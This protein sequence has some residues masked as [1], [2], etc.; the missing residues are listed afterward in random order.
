MAFLFPFHNRAASVEF[1]EPDFDYPQTVEKNA[2]ALLKKADKQTA[3]QAGVTR[4]RAL[5]ELCAAQKAIDFT[6]CFAQPALVAGKIAKTNNTPADRAMLLL[7]QAKIYSNI[8]LN[9]RWSYDRV[10]APAEP[11]PADVSEWSGLQFRNKIKALLDSAMQIEASD[12]LSHYKDVLEYSKHATTYLPTSRDFIFNQACQIFSDSFN[13]GENYATDVIE[14]ALTTAKPK[15]PEFFYWKVL[16]LGE[17]DFDSVEQERAEWLEFYEKYKNV[18]AAR[19]VLVNLLERYQYQKSTPPSAEQLQLISLAE[20][21]LKA[22]PQWYNNAALRNSLN[23]LTTPTVNLTA[24]NVVMSGRAFKV[25]L[26]YAFAK[27][28]T[29]WLYS[30]PPTMKTIGRITKFVA[31]HRAVEQRTVAV[32]PQGNATVEF[33]APKSGRYMLVANLNNVKKEDG[34]GCILLTAS[35]FLPMVIN[36][37]ENCTVITADYLTGAP[38]PGVELKCHYSW[39]KTPDLRLGTTD[40]QGMCTLE[41]PEKAGIIQFT[42][43]GQTTSF[44]SFAYLHTRYKRHYNKLESGL[45]LT[46]RA[47]YHP[48]DSLDWAVVLA[49]RSGADSKICSGVKL[50][51]YL[52]DANGQKRDTIIVTTDEYGRANG[53]FKLPKGILTGD[54][55]LY[56]QDIVGDR[57]FSNHVMV[58]DFRPP[59]FRVEVTTVSRDVPAKGGVQVCGN[60]RT[61]AGMPVA[62]ADVKVALSGVT[63]WRWFSAPQLVGNIDVKTDSEGNFTIDFTPEMLGRKLNDGR[64]YTNF[65]AEINVVAPDASTA[66]ASTVFNVGKPYS[67]GVELPERADTSAPLPLTFKAMSADGKEAPIEIEWALAPASADGK[68]RADAIVLSGKTS[69]GKPEKLDLGTLAAGGYA[70]RLVPVDT[71]LA[72]TLCL[73]QA[74]VLYNV[75]KNQVP[76]LENMPVFL[77]QTSVKLDEDG[78]GCVQV[79]VLEPTNVYVA[80]LYGDTI[81]SVEPRTLP[82]GYTAL[83]VQVAFDPAIEGKARLAVLNVLNGRSYTTEAELKKTEK[84]APELKV[85][86]FRDKITSGNTESWRIRMLAPDGKAMP[87]IPAIA[88]MYNRALDELLPMNWQSRFNLVYPQGYVSI[89]AFSTFRHSTSIDLPAPYAKVPN[90]VWPSWLFINQYY[91]RYMTRNL[92]ARLASATNQVTDFLVVED[93]EEERAAPSMD[94][95]MLKESAVYDSAGSA[96]DSDAGASEAPKEQN[97]DFRE[98]EAL[99]AFWLP[100]LVSDAEGNIDIVFTVPNALGTWSFRAL[101]W[102]AAAQTSELS[103]EAVASKPVMVQ[104][105]LPRFLRQGDVATVLATV[106]NNSGAAADIATT[107][108]LFDVEAGAVYATRTFENRIEA[109]ASA[110]VPFDIEVPTDKSAVGYR[111]RANLGKYSDGEQALIP[112]LSSSATVIESTEFYLNPDESKPFE[113]SIPAAKD[114]SLTL[115]YCQNPIWTVVRAMRGLGSQDGSSVPVLV[116]KLFSALTAKAIVGGNPDIAKTISEWK[117]NPEED[118][119]TSMLSRN[120]DLKKLMLDQTPWVQTAANESARMAALADVLDPQKAREAIAEYCAKMRELQTADGGFRWTSWSRE[121]GE[122]VTRDVLVTLGIANSLGFLPADDADLNQ[123]LDKAWAFV[124]AEAVKPKKI[125][126]DFTL[127]YI[128]SLYPRFKATPAAARL[129]RSTVKEIEKDW[130]GQNLTAKAYAVLVLKAN[131]REAVAADILASIREFAVEKEGIGMTFPSINDIRSYATIIQAYKAMNAPAAEIDALRQWVIVQAQASDNIFA[132]NPD[133]VIAAVLLTGSDWTSVPVNNNVTLNGSPLEISKIESASGYFTRSLPASGKKMDISVQPNGITPSYGSVISIARRP[134]STVKA[135][136]GRDLSIEKRVLVNRN[137]KWIETKD[138][139]L[140][141][142]LQVQLIIKAKR[143]LDYVVID[144]E[145]PATFEPVEQL[146]GYVYADGLAFYRENLDASTRL[147]IGHMPAGTYHLSYEMTANLGGRFISGV[148]TLQSQYAP[149]LTAHSGAFTV[150]VK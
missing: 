88:T 5:L 21:S 119:L 40:A 130:K 116:S 30:I 32:S 82:A 44:D 61:F 102:T 25:E 56:A 141:E 49:S 150:N 66:S 78:K 13:N 138:Y 28:I 10:D 26:S 41:H 42:K 90:I 77:P 108:E 107:V 17:R 109:D 73:P 89:S 62:G 93:C 52:E 54:Y 58:S 72:D 91:G 76:A 71:A 105:N 140:G 39:D 33:T 85:E 110:L 121:P 11:L 118:A 22:F 23:A 1:K 120:E 45:V 63:F 148:A 2:Q 111:V 92:R 70:M 131:G 145:R 69:C 3:P 100:S 67:L 19:Y 114:A 48:G 80:L 136:P 37:D 132:Y 95:A 81:L 29:V 79:G 134:M 6:N 75:T 47:I 149:E 55:T 129:I 4:L 99:Q 98:P 135:R 15:S 139:Q 36:G 34:Y 20:K 87:S 8:Y 68:F 31:T 133:Y 103:L 86:S 128:A 7:L 84:A 104:P 94:G 113:L 74:L 18:E 16:Q 112:I 14:H 53:S 142:R 97:N 126:S 64:P 125:T 117:N 137:G 115:Q 57:T 27:N 51:V 50:R 38:M 9:D 106:Y 24:P 146:P 143:A 46:S 83:P 127:A 35:T 147:F 144:D 60:A 101:A 12:P 124:Q 123:M 65:S 43:D 59:V 122:W 96:K